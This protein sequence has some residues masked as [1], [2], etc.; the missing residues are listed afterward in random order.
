MGEQLHYIEVAYYP[1]CVD[2]SLNSNLVSNSD[3]VGAYGR[4][5]MV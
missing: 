2:G 3:Q 1:N 4:A 5:L